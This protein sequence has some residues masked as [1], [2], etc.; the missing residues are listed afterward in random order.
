MLRFLAEK[1]IVF[2]LRSI[3]FAS[4]LSTVNLKIYII[5]L[6]NIVTVEKF[7]LGSTIFILCSLKECPNL[8]F[9]AKESIEILNHISA[10]IFVRKT[11]YFLIDIVFI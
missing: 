8:E 9:C 6:F 7:D 4:Q 2:P 1:E 3:D 11:K 5:Q 10:R